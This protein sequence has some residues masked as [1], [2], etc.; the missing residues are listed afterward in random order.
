MLALTLN[1][2]QK[3]YSASPLLDFQPP[4]CTVT[5]KES[6]AATVSELTNLSCP[7]EKDDRDQLLGSF[8]D[9]EHEDER[10]SSFDSL[11]TFN[12]YTTC[13][14]KWMIVREVEWSEV[15]CRVVASLSNLAV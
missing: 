12:G 2:T 3:E 11:D 13:V 1:H 4:T 6:Q 8:T 9:S 5:I 7:M 15:K 14:S 10:P